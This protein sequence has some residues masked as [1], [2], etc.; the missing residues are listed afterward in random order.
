MVQLCK[1]LGDV[2]S[3]PT[4]EHVSQVATSQRFFTPEECLKII[5]FSSGLTETTGA[6]NPDTSQPGADDTEDSAIRKSVVK[7]LPINPDTRWIYNKLEGAIIRLNQAYGFSLNG[8]ELLQV[9]RYSDGGH[10]TWHIDT[11]GEAESTRKLSLSVQLS[12]DSEYQGG[13]LEFMGVRS[14]T[15]RDIG[16]LIAFPSFLTHRVTP[17]TEGT[18]YSIVGWIHGPPFR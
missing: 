5:E 17:V 15:A 14:S 16:T 2:T 11:G 7:W 8:F 10:Y 9:S 12:D 18:R 13:D 1:L 6:T 3:P 4:N